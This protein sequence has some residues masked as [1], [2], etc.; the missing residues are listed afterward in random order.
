MWLSIS[1]DKTCWCWGRSLAKK[2]FK[3]ESFLF[4]GVN[5]NRDCVKVRAGVVR[6]CCATRR[7]QTTSSAS[8]TAGRATRWGW[9]PPPA[10]S[11]WSPPRPPTRPYTAPSPTRPPRSCKSG[12]LTTSSYIILHYTAAQKWLQKGQKTSEIIFGISFA[13]AMA[14]SARDQIKGMVEAGQPGRGIN[15]RI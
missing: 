14:N 15:L 8:C 12:E 6:A 4:A 2:I 3:R 5:G 11:P 1:S 7:G 13:K 10:S 9:W